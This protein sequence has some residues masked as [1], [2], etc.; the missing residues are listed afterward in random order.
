MVKGRSMAKGGAG[1]KMALGAAMLGAVAL[2]GC[3]SIHD[4][5]GYVIDQTMMQTV[6]PG[7][8][9]RASVEQTLGRPTFVSQFGTP[10][11]YYVAQDTSQPPFRHP[12]TTK[13]VVIRVQFDPKGNVAM[14]DRANVTGQP[15]I[16][17]EGDLTPTLGRHRSF[18]EDLFGNIGTVGA[19]GMG[20]SGGGAGGGGGGGGGGPNGS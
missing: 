19:G 13:E 15:H 18:L 6:L 16:T 2:S 20:G 5:R 7:I 11:W 4:H 1:R 9:N 12:R 3:A 17:P 8:D 10:V 14:V